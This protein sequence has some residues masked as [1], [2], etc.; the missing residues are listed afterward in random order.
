MEWWTYF[1]VVTNVCDGCFDYHKAVCNIACIINYPQITVGEAVQHVL[2]HKMA[3]SQGKPSTTVTTSLSRITKNIQYKAIVPYLPDTN[4]MDINVFENNT[5]SD[6]Y[7][8]DMTHCVTRSKRFNCKCLYDTFANYCMLDGK[9]VKKA[10]VSEL[11]S[12]EVWYERAG[13]ACLGMRGVTFKNWLA[14]LERLRTW[15]NE[16]VLYALS[17]LFQRNAIVFSCGR[18]WTTL[19][20]LPDMDLGVVQEMCKTTLLYLGN[21]LYAMLRRRLFSLERPIPFDLEDMQM[22]RPLHQDL[23]ERHMY[24]EMRIGSDYETLVQSDEVTPI[25]DIKPFQE[26]GPPTTHKNIFDVNYIPPE[27]VI[28]QEPGLQASTLQTVISHIIDQPDAIAKSIKQ[29]II[30]NTVR[31]IADKHSAT[32]ALNVFIQ[33]HCGPP[34]FGSK[35]SGA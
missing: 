19:E 33:E 9:E 23:N 30:D 24:F 26:E 34:A 21:N 13:S 25:P 15:P 22:M 28:K 2:P 1:C 10:L 11:K 29:E 6:Q 35:M 27:I 17:V 14:K 12:K 20:D 32:C 8:L 5:L 16:L 18:V 4:G 31:D 3:A 7:Y